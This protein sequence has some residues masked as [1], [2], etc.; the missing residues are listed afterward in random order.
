MVDLIA[1]LAVGYLGVVAVLYGVQRRLLYFPDRTRPEHRLNGLE[2]VELR[3]GDGLDLFAWWRPAP[4]PGRPVVAYFH[5]NAGHIGDR[6]GKLAPFL[7]AGLGL[8]AVSYR[9][10]AGNPGRPSEPGLYADG[11]A[12]LDFLER[13]GVAPERTVLYGESLGSAVAVYAATRA[14]AP[15]AAV[16]LESPFTSIAD[17]AAHHYFYV[18]ARWLVRDRFDA[19]ASVARVRAPLLVLHGERDRTVPVRFA[20][21][22]FAAAAEP[23]EA[24]FLPEAGHDDL[25]AHGAAAPI[26]G[27][28]ERHAADRST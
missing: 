10:Y 13:A 12:A 26:L 15:V 9:G 2:R 27:F 1:A 7:D 25:Y 4:A 18:P 14:R 28:I 6:V 24:L 3:T 11:V 22:L 8:L 5:G 21:R 16:V 19:R 23:K 17:V 20:R